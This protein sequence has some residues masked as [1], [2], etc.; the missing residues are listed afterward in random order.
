MTSANNQPLVLIVDDEAGFRELARLACENAGFDVVEAADG[1]EAI[2]CFHRNNPGIVLL[3]VV[4][5]G[6]DGLQ[7][8][9]SS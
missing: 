6:L 8:S 4:M 1:T 2:G 9:I 7:R 5:P 3:D